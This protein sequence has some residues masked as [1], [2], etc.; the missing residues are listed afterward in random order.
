MFRVQGLRAI[1][2][3]KRGKDRGGGG[4]EGKGRVKEVAEIRAGRVGGDST[5]TSKPSWWRDEVAL[6]ALAVQ[7]ASWNRVRTYMF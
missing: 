2:E 6:F 5:T 4:K 1:T 3:V 7:P